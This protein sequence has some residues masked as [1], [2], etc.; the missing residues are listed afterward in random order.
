MTLEQLLENEIK[1]IQNIPQNPY[2]QVVNLIYDN[3]CLQNNK[4]V[5][6]GVG[7]AGLIAD[8]ISDKFNSIGVTSIYIDPLKSQHGTLGVINKNDILFLI[9]NSGKTDEIIQFL[10][11]AQ[12]LS[13][14][15]KSILITRNIDTFLYKNC[16]FVLLTGETH[17]NCTLGLVPTISTTVM[18]VIGNILI[19]KLEEKINLTKYEYGLYHKGGYIGLLSGL[20]KK[21]LL[22]EIIE[23]ENFKI[24]GIFCI[25][26]LINNKLY[27]EKSTDI[28]NTVKKTIVELI[29]FKS[30]TK[31][32]Q[33]N[34]NIYGIEA[35]EFEIMEKIEDLT[36]IDLIY[37]KYLKKFKPRM[38]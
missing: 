22:Q 20:H 38:N 36:I 29:N 27:I 11:L 12:N 3:V 21:Y 9:S 31:K 24:S 19:Y 16:N 26:N 13:K 4:L 7:K 32:L 10:Q 28:F 34:F 23:I 1:A 35:F 37:Q 5:F 30:N 18:N 8:L 25:R 17:E 2:D 6:S 33:E 15:I 14:N